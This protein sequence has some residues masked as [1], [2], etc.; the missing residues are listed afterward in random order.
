[1]LLRL[2]NIIKCLLS[3]VLLQIIEYIETN[4]KIQLIIKQIEM[5]LVSVLVISLLSYKDVE[6]NLNIRETEI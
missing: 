6:W 2:S 4:T 1:M 5:Y 3:H